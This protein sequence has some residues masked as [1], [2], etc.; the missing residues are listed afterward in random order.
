MSI[1]GNALLVLLG[2]VISS[3]A[4]FVTL[5][6]QNRQAVGQKSQAARDQR[7]A[8]W[9]GIQ[10]K[11]VITL[12]DLLPKLAIET[13]RSIRSVPPEGKQSRRNPLPT[14]ID[15]PSNE[16]TAVQ[17]TVLALCSRLDDR[18]LVD[19]VHGYMRAVKA[20]YGQKTPEDVRATFQASTKEYRELIDSLGTTLR[21]LHMELK[22]LNTSAAK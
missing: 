14:L 11:T 9:N 4:A 16:F 17:M 10:V 12:Q 3:L 2:G 7:V 5:T 18:E 20:T 13:T 8:D 21:V 19:R 22:E 1:W 15:G 6:V